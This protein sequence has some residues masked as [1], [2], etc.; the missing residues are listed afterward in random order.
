MSRTGTILAALGQLTGDSVHGGLLKSIA[1]LSR[2]LFFILVVP[3]LLAGELTVYIY[4]NSIAL[5]I[6][7]IAIVGMNDELPRIVSGDAGKARGFFR[8]SVVLNLAV[9]LLLLA[10]FIWPSVHLGIALFA[11][12][13]IASRFV[14]GIVRS[15]D[16][17]AYERLQNLPWVLFII[18]AVALQLDNAFDLL[19]ARAAST[20]LV[21]W[22][23]LYAID[24]Q[25]RDGARTEP[26]ALTVLF[27]RAL[28]HGITKLVSNLSLLGISRAPVLLPVWLSMDADLDPV[29][30]A[31]AVGEIVVQFGLIPANRAYAA[32][33]RQPPT[34]LRDWYHAIT[35]SLLLAAALAGLSIVILLIANTLRMLPE[36]APG[37]AMLTQAFVLYALVSAFYALRYLVWARGVL[38][39]RVV[40]LSVGMLAGCAVA[41]W[42]VAVSYTHLRA[43]ET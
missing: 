28:S 8:S 42:R 1:L 3:V 19:I 13:T 18:C 12:A 24:S 11:V 21:T 39:Y 27:R 25:S 5:I 15:V 34:K 14:G 4:I 10:M 36:Q 31:V 30:Y 29:A 41:I 38:E 7:I 16:P 23:C 9:M 20:V 37:N 22:Y 2:L 17:A 43:H 33:C 6:A 32:W 26:I 35:L 40:L